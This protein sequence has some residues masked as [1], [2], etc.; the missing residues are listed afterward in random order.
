[1]RHHYESLSPRRTSTPQSLRLL[2]DRRTPIVTI[3]PQRVK[4]IFLQNGRY[5]KMV[6]YFFYTVYAILTLRNMFFSLLLIRTGHCLGS[7]LKEKN[8]HVIS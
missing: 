7:V 4:P 2:G 6:K 3:R 5:T 1:M 8:C